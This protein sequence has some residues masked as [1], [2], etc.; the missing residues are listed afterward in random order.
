MLRP[1]HLSRLTGALISLG[2]LSTSVQAQT[3]PRIEPDRP[4]DETAPAPSDPRQDPRSTGATARPG[5]NLSQRLERTE[6]VIRPPA[7][8]NPE[9]SVRTPGQ[10]TATTPVIRPP[11]E[12]GGNPTVQ[13]K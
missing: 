1:G 10:G 11:G 9:M 7:D 5:E 8:L 13:P 4:R 6:G 3:T 2:V 12:P